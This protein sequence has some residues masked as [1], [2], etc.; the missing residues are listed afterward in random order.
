MDVATAV[1]NDDAVSAIVPPSLTE[2][3]GAYVGA[4]VAFKGECVSV[5]ADG[6]GQLGED[7]NIES[8]AGEV[9]HEDHGPR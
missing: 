6:A 5:F 8:T 3:K 9:G 2:D 4:S 1:T 7:D